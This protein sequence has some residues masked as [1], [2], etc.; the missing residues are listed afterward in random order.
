MNGLMPLIFI[1]EPISDVI[2]AAVTTTLFFLT[3]NKVLRQQSDSI[4]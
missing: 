2:A 1:A 3:M 4:G